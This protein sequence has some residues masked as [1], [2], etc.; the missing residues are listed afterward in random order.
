[1]NGDWTFRIMIL[2]KS[3]FA[4]VYYIA[5]F[6]YQKILDEMYPNW[7]NED[8]FELKDEFIEEMRNKCNSTQ[9]KMFNEI[10]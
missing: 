10:L 6:D 1:M 8:L 7:R 4:R 9:L 5:C 3:Q 2:T